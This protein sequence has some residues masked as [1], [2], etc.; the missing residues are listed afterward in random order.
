MA[1]V[2]VL[3]LRAA[4]TNCD[5]ET[6]FAFELAGATA[7][8]IHV[9][10]LRE[11]PSIL[12]RYQ[13]LALPG[14]FTY[15]DDLGAGTVLANELA[16]SLR[17]PIEEFL[18]KDRLVIGICNGF[19]VLVKMGLLPRIPGPDGCRQATL[20]PNLSA[21]FEDR[22]VKL[23]VRAGRSVFVEQ[24]GVI[25]LPVAHAE[26]RFVARDEEVLRLLEANGQIVFQYCDPAGRPTTDY[27]ANPNG[28]ALGIAGVCD[29]TGRIL[30]MMPH[31]ERHVLGIHH[32]RWTRRGVEPEGDGLAL[33]RNA[34]AYFR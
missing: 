24:D 4:G 15:G 31:P 2:N 18:E 32:P 16:S 6:A 27:P 19:Q 14:G 8:R 11:N 26:G 13:V 9:N 34:V 1:K 12:D 33:F 20:A 17:G 3:V 28:S 22:W 23:Q 21:R 25:E 5:E 10:R 7:E 30:G 29:P